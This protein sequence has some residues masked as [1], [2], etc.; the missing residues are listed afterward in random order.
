MVLLIALAGKL[1][2]G[3]GARAERAGSG[4]ACRL[5]GRVGPRR[6][7]VVA[8]A[9]ARRARSRA[10]VVTHDLGL[11]WNIADRLAVMYMGRI[12]EVGTPEQVFA[13]PRRP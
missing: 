5:A 12:V 3:A 7:S 13:D 4:R 11:A 6:D 2:P 1:A 8:A 9:A 10:L